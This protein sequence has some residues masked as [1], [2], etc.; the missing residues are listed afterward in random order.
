MV[1]NRVDHTKWVYDDKGQRV[2]RKTTQG[3]K[4]A[5]EVMADAT[6]GRITVRK[7]KKYK[8]KKGTIK[9]A[10]DIVRG[11][12][13]VHPTTETGQTYKT[14]TGGQLDVTDVIKKIK[15]ERY[16]RN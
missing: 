4:T 11:K 3:P 15:G 14:G 6:R 9:M 2:K 5:E 1:S 10:K 16:G 12:A 7:K 13:T 8:K